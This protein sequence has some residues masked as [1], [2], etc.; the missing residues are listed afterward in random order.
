MNETFDAQINEA[1]GA[2][3]HCEDLSTV[4]VNVTLRCNQRCTHCHLSAGPERDEQMDEET[5]REILEVLERLDRPT[6]DITGGAPELNQHL[7]LLVVGAH[8]RKCPV[9]VRTNLT[10]LA[11]N[12]ELSELYASHQVKLVASLP[13]YMRENVE[14]QR[15][16][17]VYDRSIET[18]QKLNG[19]GYG[20]DPNMTL[21]LVYNPAGA[22]LPPSQ[23][24]LEMDYRSELKERFGLRFTNLLTIT[25]MP[26]GRFAEMLKR[27]GELKEY[28]RTLQEAFNPATIPSLMCRHQVNVGPDGRLY[29]C[30]FHL[31]AGMP[32]NQNMPQHVSELDPERLVGRRI[33]TAPHCFACTAGAGSSC[34]GALAE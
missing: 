3:L 28:H 18:L 34:T 19:L 6:V 16:E 10:A 22:F 24:E 4:Q 5:V 21:D 14:S 9:M 31:A 32:V 30:D 2:P 17:G 23:E 29:D 26:L 20:V 25:N 7:P 11:D 33:V 1:Q 12:W 8:E 13:C 15:G 27:S